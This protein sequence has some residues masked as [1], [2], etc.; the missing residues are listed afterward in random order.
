MKI[1]GI[2]GSCRRLGNT[3]ILVKEALMEAQKSGAEVDIVR[4]TDYK[5][6]PCE[7]DATCMF[8]GKECKHKGKDDHDFLL[9]MMYGFDGVI[10]G[11]PC[12]I[13]EVEAVV[14]QF[15]DRLFVLSSQPSQMI[16]KPAA[17]IIPY[18]TRGL[19]LLCFPATNDSVAPA[20]D[21]YYRQSAGPYSGNE[22]GGR[23]PQGTGESPQDRNGSC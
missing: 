11:A 14:K 13:L 6:F 23:R 20:R 1:L 10:F 3:E 5:I 7:G 21:A 12:Y 8:M 2:V 16:G 15:I 4:W 9:K 18:A 19:D 17:I 22:P